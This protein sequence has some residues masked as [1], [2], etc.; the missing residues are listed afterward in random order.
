MEKEDGR[1][2][3]PKWK[4]SWRITGRLAST[5]AA[6]RADEDRSARGFFFPLACTLSCAYYYPCG[7]RRMFS[8]C[9]TNHFPIRHSDFHQ[10]SER[11]RPALPI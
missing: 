7:I 4:K 11:P 9:L 10:L 8:F 6:H 1:S 5:T 2:G 3:E